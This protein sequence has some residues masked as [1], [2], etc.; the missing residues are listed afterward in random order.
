[1][2][3]QNFSPDQISS[4]MHLAQPPPHLP[5]LRYLAASAR[6]QD[7]FCISFALE[8]APALRVLV[9]RRLLVALPAQF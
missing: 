9:F 7:W 1:M 8:L 6:S 2:V 3:F 4:Q 5:P